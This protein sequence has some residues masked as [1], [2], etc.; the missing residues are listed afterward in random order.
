MASSA[1][2][3]SMTK[4]VLGVVDQ[5]SYDRFGIAALDYVWAYAIFCLAVYAELTRFRPLEVNT[6]IIC[7]CTPTLKPMLNLAREYS[8]IRSSTKTTSATVDTFKDKHPLK[9]EQTRSKSDSD[10]EATLPSLRLGNVRWSRE[11]V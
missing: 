9:L 7:G 6:G 1:F 5:H 3:V 2:L 8:A 10:L 11:I 4:F